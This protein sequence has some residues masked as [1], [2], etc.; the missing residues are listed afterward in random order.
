MTTTTNL[1]GTVVP[2]ADPNLVDSSA[3]DAA[4]LSQVATSW[5]ALSKCG[6]GW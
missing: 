1:V 6:T 2:N 4:I 5:N 3:S